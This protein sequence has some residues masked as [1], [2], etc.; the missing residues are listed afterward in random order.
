MSSESIL[1]V[2]IMAHNEERVVSKAINSCLNQISPPQFR[3][4]VLVVANGCTD[5]TEEIVADIAENFP[6]RLMLISMKEKG[7]TKALNRVIAYLE[8][9]IEREADVPYVIFLDADC[10]FVGDDAF[11]KFVKRFEENPLLCAVGANCIPNVSGVSRT[12]LVLD[13]YR[14][15]N[16]LSRL[17]PENGISGGA[18]CIKSD[19]LRKLSFPE[20]QMADDM[21]VS[22]KLDGW[23]FRDHAIS[24][25]YAIPGDLRAELTKRVRQEIATQRYFEYHRYLLETGGQTALFD[26]PLEEKYRWIGFSNSQVLSMWFRVNSKKDK[27][28]IGLNVVIR[29]LA[30][31]AAGRKIA[32]I[33]RNPTLDFWRVER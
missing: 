15:L 18:Y 1:L 28:L 25:V 19:V 30:K 24:V 20:F 31:I 9:E 23:M 8:G 21:Y 29:F 17:L 16:E 27:M 7:K 11:I 3:V 14:A 32:K 22:L 5:R 6:N 12:N 13:M 2:A 33:E 10:E 26:T 4:R